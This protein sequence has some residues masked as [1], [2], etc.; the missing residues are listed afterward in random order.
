VQPSPVRKGIHLLERDLNAAFLKA[1]R[2]PAEK[3]EQAAF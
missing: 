3:S 2:L 1:K